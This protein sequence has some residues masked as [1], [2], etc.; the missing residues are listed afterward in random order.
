MI[1][2]FTDDFHDFHLVELPLKLRQGVGVLAAEATREL[3][4]LC[5]RIGD[6]DNAYTYQPRAETVDIIAGTEADLEIELD[7]ACWDQLRAGSIADTKIQ[8]CFGV[9]CGD[10]DNVSIAQWRVAL[11][12]IY[13]K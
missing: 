4:P 12:I 3:E 6:S 2:L 7:Q 10:V 8:R 11:Q 9:E 13:K 1:T 5:V